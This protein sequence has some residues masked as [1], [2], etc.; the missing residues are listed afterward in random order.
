M[1][2]TALNQRTRRLV[3]ASAA[4]V[5]L[6][7]SL[8]VEVAANQ[9]PTEDMLYLT[10]PLL[11][12]FYSQ[13]DSE[14]LPGPNGPVARSYHW[15]R[16]ESSFPLWP[17]IAGS[18]VLQIEHLDPSPEGRVR[19]EIGG[20]APLF[21]TQ[22]AQL[23]TMHLLLPPNDASRVHLV[24]TVPPSGGDRPLGLIVSGIQCTSFGSAS[25]AS[26]WRLFGGLPFTLLL[27]ATLSTLMG[28]SPLRSLGVAAIVLAGTAL[29][30]VRWP[31][32]SRAIQPALQVLLLAATIGVGVWRLR[33]RIHVR[34]W[35]W[36][37]AGVWLLSTAAFFSPT[38]RIDGTEYYAYVRSLF[39]DGDW[40]FINEL[41]PALTPFRTGNFA[42]HVTPTG[43]TP[44]LASVGPAL[45]WMP[46][47]LVGHAI[48]LLG[49][50][51]GIGWVPDGY[52]PP[53]VVLV[54]LATA[55]MGLVSMLGCYWITRRWVSAPLAALTA[56]TIYFGSNLLY[57]AQ[58][59]GSFAHSQSAA[60]ATMFTLA[61]LRLGEQP[62]M[63]RWIGLGLATGAM[64][65]TYWITAFL[66]VVPLLLMLPH[67]FRRVGKADWRGAGHLFGGAAVAALVALVVFSPQMVAWKL[68]YGNWLSAPHGTDYITPRN[69]KL[70][71]VLFSPLYGTAWW[72][73]AFFAGLLGSIWFAIRR[74]S[75]GIALFVAAAIYIGYN[76]SILRWWAGGSFGMRRFSALAP[77][78]A[79]GLATI[80]WNL[81]RWPALVVALGGALSG[82][83]T[84]MTVRYVN[85]SIP[86][87]PDVLGELPLRGLML[88]PLGTSLGSL[89]TVIRNAWVGSYLASP[90]VANTL[91]LAA[92]LALIAGAWWLLARTTRAPRLANRRSPNV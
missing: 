3:A 19:V 33:G 5:L 68:I 8:F 75:P 81:R 70:A 61:A 43:Y 11:Q 74:P 20:H 44:N 45:L 48:T 60:T 39:I 64:I 69:I 62:T 32:E 90:N 15:T 80:F 71:L 77:M 76:A 73:P 4:V 35:E 16:P 53:Y 34:R 6:V 82:W 56:I 23:R 72:T 87:D 52:A 24:Q 86:H 50:A 10:Q 46:F 27:V 22:S 57:Y 78:F 1:I 66:L 41:D 89:T 85:Y 55:L 36:V 51:V 88:N 9:C 18:G 14:S 37:L 54:T 13:E 30:G 40:H 59:E 49:N 7:A 28:A 83:G 38:V 2:N 58:F 47:W 63:R 65:V 25:L 91:L 92:I 67:L 29:L 42:I 17:A 79:V 26:G 12:G 31:W 21:A 84:I